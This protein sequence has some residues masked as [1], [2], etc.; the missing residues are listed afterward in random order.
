[1]KLTIQRLMLGDS[2]ATWITIATLDSFV[3]LSSAERLLEKTNDEYFTYRVVDDKGEVLYSQIT[4][5]G[6]ACSYPETVIDRCKRLAAAYDVHFDDLKNG[7]VIISQ[8]TLEYLL[9]VVDNNG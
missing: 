9:T 8:W 5:N 3:P 4:N 2:G 7:N 1:M 6:P